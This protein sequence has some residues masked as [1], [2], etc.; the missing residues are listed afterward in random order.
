M[1]SPSGPLSLPLQELVLF[2]STTAK[3]RQSPLKL[4]VT[5]SLLREV[6]EGYERLEM[7]NGRPLLHVRTR[8]C[9]S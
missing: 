1:A 8:R 4:I 6:R 7:R 3:E 9:R 2:I 5:P